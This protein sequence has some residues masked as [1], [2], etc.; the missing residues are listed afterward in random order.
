[1]SSDPQWAPDGTQPPELHTDPMLPAITDD[2]LPPLANPRVPTLD[3]RVL[4]ELLA[5]LEG[6][7]SPPADALDDV[8]APA[9]NRSTA[10]PLAAPRLP[11]ESTGFDVDSL[12]APRLAPDPTRF[13]AEPTAAPQLAVDPSDLGVPDPDNLAAQIEL[14][15]V[16]LPRPD[17]ENSAAGGRP[18][19]PPRTRMSG[20]TPGAGQPLRPRISQPLGA[21]PGRAPGS[22]AGAPGS[23]AGAGGSPLGHSGVGPVIRSEYGDFRPPVAR[24]SDVPTGLTGL[25]RKS[26]SKV[27]SVLF[28]VVFIA[29]FVLILIQALASV[30]TASAGH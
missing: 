12:A 23:R 28:T 26:R 15:A 18:A 25:T 20:T 2:M 6:D 24:V 3:D 7:D 1:M 8:D 16:P 19:Q 9:R 22:R 29:I 11:P 4:A 21:R 14:G 30:F 13:A 27:G 10:D 17:P 5:E